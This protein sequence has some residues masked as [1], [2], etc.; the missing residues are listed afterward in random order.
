MELDDAEAKRKQADLDDEAARKRKE[1]ED[2]L[3]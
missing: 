2:R 3:L 1:E